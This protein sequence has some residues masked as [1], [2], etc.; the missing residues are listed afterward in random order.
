MSV[1]WEME[2]PNDGVLDPNEP[3][4]HMELSGTWLEE[5]SWSVRKWKMV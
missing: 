2:K 5:K 4:G 3:E 1:T